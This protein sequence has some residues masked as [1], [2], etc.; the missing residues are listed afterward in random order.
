MASILS[1]LTE[2]RMIRGLPAGRRLVSAMLLIVALT[3]GNGPAAAQGGAIPPAGDQGAGVRA[4]EL[5][6]TKAMNIDLPRDARDVLIADPLVA[7]IVIKSPRRAYVIGLKAGDTNAFF[8]DEE[9]N[10]ILQMD[11]RVEKDLTALRKALS[12]LLPGTELAV[13]SINGDIVLSG[14]ARSVEA[15]EN[16]RLIA[17]RFVDT[18]AGIINMVGVTRP[19]QVLLQVRVTEMRR[20]VA[21]RLGVSLIGR[22]SG[23]SFNSGAQGSNLFSDLFGAAV[24]SGSIGSYSSIQVLLEALEEDGYI[25]TLAEPNLTALSGETANF[26][27]GGEFPVPVA[28]DNNGQVT[29]EFKPFGVGLKFT[30][31]V[32]DSGK[33]SMRVSTEVSALSNEGAF[34]LA[35]IRV[36]GLTVR[37]AETT[38]EIPSGGSL[39][40]GGLLRNDAANNVR[41]LPGLANIPVLG[42][43]FRSTDFQREETE[44]VVIAIPYIVKP[45]SP[46][47]LASPTDGFAPGGDIDQF[48]LGKLYQRYPGTAGA[49]AVPPAGPIGFIME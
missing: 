28:R 45:T 2:R 24:I 41:G 29:L 25:K 39:V 46:G 4:V 44:L 31:V 10:R 9:G 38:V 13:R 15:V 26:L 37:R 6:T 14:E 22:D 1:T 17:R 3:M 30:P 12:D 36:P 42:T 48:L 34:E 43:L 23:F 8:L 49:M 40:L 32:L 16:A 11:I 18:D 7:D 5:T 47:K 35:D 33:I 20:T 27:A 21:R 19:E